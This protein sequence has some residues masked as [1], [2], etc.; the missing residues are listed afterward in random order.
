MLSEQ[1]YQDLLQKAKERSTPID[2]EAL[3]EAGVL[4]KKGAWYEI[5]KSKELPKEAMAQVSTMRQETGK[6]PLV[7]FRKPSKA[8]ARIVKEQEG[9]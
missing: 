4:K 7:K 6:P 1:D 5:L 9:A 2:F 3:I 8:L